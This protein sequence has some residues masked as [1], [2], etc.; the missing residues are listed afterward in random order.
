MISSIVRCRLD[1]NARVNRAGIFCPICR[2]VG[3][4][5]A[6]RM[7]NEVTLGGGYLCYDTVPI[8]FVGAH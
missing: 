2:S 3:H 5:Y 7:S 8:R 4:R 1:E 6:A